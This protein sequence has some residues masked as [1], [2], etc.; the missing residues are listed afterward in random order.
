MVR[1]LLL[2]AV[3]CALAGG[4]GAARANAALTYRPVLPG[5]LASPHFA[6]H[7]ESDVTKS[8]YTTETQAGDLLAFLEQAY[9]SLTAL[10]W[11]APID[12]SVTTPGLVDIYIEDLSASKVDSAVSIDGAG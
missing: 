6:V 3:L 11:Q 10:G 2:A 9:T 7:Y 5:Y 4:F 1:R 8:E 12:D